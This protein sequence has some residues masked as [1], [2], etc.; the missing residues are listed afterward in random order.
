MTGNR[1]AAPGIGPRGPLT[2]T[3]VHGA[4]ITEPLG[5]AP[6]D[7]RES[8]LAEALDFALGVNSVFRSRARAEG[9]RLVATDIDWSAGT[10]PEVAGSALD[11]L[12]ALCGR[13]AAAARLAG[14]GAGLL[15]ER[16]TPSAGR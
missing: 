5:L 14:D 10:G 11:V 8:H 13:P 15:I 9:L 16:T 1:R 7:H 12:S 6:T 4:D 2:D 3:I